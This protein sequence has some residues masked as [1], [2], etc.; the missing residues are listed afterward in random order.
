MLEVI[1]AD[2]LLLQPGIIFEGTNKFC[3]RWFE[4]AHKHLLYV[5]PLRNLPL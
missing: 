4:G 5:K 3:D 1:S 2:G